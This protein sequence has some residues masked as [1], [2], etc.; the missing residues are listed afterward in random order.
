MIRRL[1]RIAAEDSGFT[2]I[3]LIAATTLIAMV[4]SVLAGIF[5]STMLAQQTVQQ[6]TQATNDAQVAASGLDYAIRNASEFQLTTVNT[7]D[8]LLVVRTATAGSSVNW[9]CAS[10]Y[11]S[12]S[13]KELR[14]NISAVGT[15]VTAPTSAQLS[16]WTL[17]AQGV[18]PT[19]GSTIFGASGG[20]LSVAFNV[21]HATDDEPTAINFTTAKLTSVVETHA[22]Y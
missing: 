21:L 3:E 16:A 4:M 5:I 15:L 9:T 18:S 14:Q 8:Q 10:W 22:C 6:R 13:G 7:T 20:K 11:F 1:R 2:L 17:V 12:K 19:A